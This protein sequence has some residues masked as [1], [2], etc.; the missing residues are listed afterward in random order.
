MLEYLKF[1]IG[2]YIGGFDTVE[3]TVENNKIDYKARHDDSRDV[4]KLPLIYPEG[5]LNRVDDEILLKEW[6]RLKARDWESEYADPLVLDGESWQL[7]FIEDGKEYEISGL[8]DYPSNWVKFIDWI[9]RLAPEMKFVSPETI[10]KISIR[11]K[12]KENF[13]YGSVDGEE[14]IKLHRRNQTLTYKKIKSYDDYDSIH[15]YRLGFDIDFLLDHC[16]GYFDYTELEEIFEPVDKM[17]EV[18]IIRHNATVDK[19]LYACN[20]NSLPNWNEFI[21][22]LHNYINDVD[23]AIF[24]PENYFRS[25]D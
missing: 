21:E 18:E 22:E 8:N 1:T 11:Y 15:I 5:N 16:E 17:I 3:L 9:D 20:Y 4:D 2:G 25:I 23:G 12:F 19:R 24:L 13:Q 6:D 14:I 10:D 7:N